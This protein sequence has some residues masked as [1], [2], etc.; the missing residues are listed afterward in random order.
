MAYEAGA[1]CWVRIVH[2]LPLSKSPKRTMSGSDDHYSNFTDKGAEGQLAKGHLSDQW[3]CRD[4]PLIVLCQLLVWT[5]FLQTLL[6][7]WAGLLPPPLSGLALGTHSALRAW[8]VQLP[9][10]SYS[11]ALQAYAGSLREDVR[12]NGSG[13]TGRGWGGWDKKPEIKPGS[14]QT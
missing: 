1:S 9:G 8:L 7:V 11:V 14:L 13:R 3:Q 10:L 5:L 6:Q 2:E 12:F 4:A